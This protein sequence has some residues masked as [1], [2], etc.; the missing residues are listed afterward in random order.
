MIL[1]FIG[2]IECLR[3]VAERLSYIDS[4]A[5]ALS[6]LNPTASLSDVG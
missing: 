4:F 2:T 1:I 3:V 5:L 6:Q